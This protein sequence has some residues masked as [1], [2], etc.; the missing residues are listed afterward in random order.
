MD[1]STGRQFLTSEECDRRWRAYQQRDSRL[2]LMRQV[3]GFYSSLL[4][5]ITQDPTYF[6]VNIDDHGFHRGDG[7]FEA[8]RIAF[9]KPYLLG[10]HLDRLER[11][12]ARVGLALPHSREEIKSILHDLTRLADEESLVLRIYI[13]RGGGGFGVSPTESPESQMFAVATQFQP[14]AP[15]VWEKGYSLTLSPVEVK[16]GDFA[17]IKSLNY[18]PNVLMKADALKRGFDYGVGVDERGFI[19]EGATENIVIVNR[20]GELCHPRFDRM[21]DGCTMKRLFELAP[22]IPTLSLKAETDFT[23]DD[24]RTAQEILIVGTT[25]DVSPVTRF[26]D[27]KLPVGARA[28]ELLQLLR[29]DQLSPQA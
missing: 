9:R 27:R 21:L 25:V 29:T 15:E 4:G 2:K 20:H 16:S 3:R 17:K 26:E 13:T 28:R 6:M 5:G 1:A 10:P 7:V 8:I 22:S 11:S 12:A 18:L 19:T 24:L 14:A 23:V